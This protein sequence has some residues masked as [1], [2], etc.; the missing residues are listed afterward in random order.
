MNKKKRNAIIALIVIYFAL[1]YFFNVIAD[2]INIKDIGTSKA[3]D[4]TFKIISSTEN[5]D[6]EET[7]KKY[8]KENQIDLQ[9]DYAGTIEIM[10][11]LNN[12]E[13]YDAVWCSNSI[14]LYYVK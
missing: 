9:I 7:L 1:V 12:G 11:K 14:W 6:I 13:N 2:N 3:S 5:K 10:D 4:K 8:A